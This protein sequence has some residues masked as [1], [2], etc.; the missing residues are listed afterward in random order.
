[1]LQCA[2]VA[3]PTIGEDTLVLDGPGGI[4]LRGV[5]SPVNTSEQSADG[6]FQVEADAT[7]SV[8]S[9][10]GINR[11]LVKKTGTAKGERFRIV[12]VDVGE[13]FTT[14]FLRHASNFDF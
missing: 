14:I 4:T 13:V 11:S 9:A 7:I 3:D 6:G 12:S 10:A 1:M 5:W 2:S 8:N